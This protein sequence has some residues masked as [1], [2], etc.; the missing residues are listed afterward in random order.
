[1]GSEHALER[2]KHNFLTKAPKHSQETECFKAVWVDFKGEPF[3]PPQKK[4]GATGQLGMVN[5]DNLRILRASR[6]TKPLEYEAGSRVGAKTMPRGLFGTQMESNKRRFIAV[7]NQAN[8]G[9]PKGNQTIKRSIRFGQDS[10]S[11]GL[12]NPQP[13]GIFFGVGLYGQ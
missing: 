13:L 6:E 8:C 9:N 10:G 7:W 12:V 3:S 5:A 11:V 2:L 4:T 1:M